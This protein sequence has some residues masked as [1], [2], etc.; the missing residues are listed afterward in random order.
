[1]GRRSSKI[2]RRLSVGPLV[3]C[4]GL[5]L[6]DVAATRPFPFLRHLWIRSAN[7]S[8]GCASSP[9]ASP[10]LFS[11]TKPFGTCSSFPPGLTPPPTAPERKSILPNRHTDVVDAA[12]EVSGNFFELST[13]LAEPV[14]NLRTDRLLPV[15]RRFPCSDC[16]LSD[17]A[18]ASLLEGDERRG[19]FASLSTIW[20]RV[21]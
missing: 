17:L 21:G 14:E 9:A 20:R 10:A 12:P 11:V 19:E 6:G 4:R 13:L 15:V 1:M 18:M 2:A 16:K 8:P 5:T 7:S 3:N